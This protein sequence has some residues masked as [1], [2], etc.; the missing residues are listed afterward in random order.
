M[1]L[2]GLIYKG[3]W[4]AVT[5]QPQLVDGVGTTNYCYIIIAQSNATAYNIY[6]RNLGS[7]NKS[8]IALNYIYYNGSTWEPV[9]EGTGGGGSGT[10]TSVDASGGTGILV[11]GGPI[12]N[13]GTLH[14][15]N[16][17]PDQVVTLTPGTGIGVS[18]TYPNFSIA[19]TQSSGSTVTP[20]ALTTSGDTNITLQASGT[21]ASA[22]LQAVK[23]TV[24][25]QGTLDD[26]RISSAAIWNAKQ[27]QL[28]GAGFVKASGTTITYDNSTYL[29]SGVTS[30]NGTG[31]LYSSGT[32]AIS[33]A[34]TDSGNAG[35][36]GDSAH[37]PVITT[38]QKG[39]VTNISTTPIPLTS[40]VTSVVG[41]VGEIFASG[42]TAI[43]VGLPD[44]GIAGVY[45]GAAQLPIIT[46]DSK[47]RIT[48]IS[49]TSIYT[50][51]VTS[52][53][54]I[55]TT[56]P[57]QGGGDLSADR[58]LS[59]LQ[60]SSGA[61]GALLAA[62][63]VT[64]NSKLS[65]S[66][67]INT[68]F[69]VVG[70]GNLTVDRIFSVADA[71]ADGVTKGVSAFVA[72]DFNTTSGVTS[73]DYTNGQQSTSGTTGFLPAAD[74]NTF[75]LKVPANRVLTINGNAQD[76]SS[77]RSW[78]ISASPAGSN[79][80]V[81]Y[82]S[83][84]ST[85]GATNTLIDTDTNLVLLTSSGITTPGPSPA[86]V[87]LWGDSRSGLG[88]LHIT[89]L[90]GADY[91]LQSS[92]SQKVL[93]FLSIGSVL[94]G[95]GNFVTASNAGSTAETVKTYDGTNMLPNYAYHK[96]IAASTAN[97][98]GELFWSATGRG[99][100]MGNNVYG[101]GVKW[102][103]T[104]GFPVYSS[105]Q[106]IHVGYT[107]TASQNATTTNPSAWLNFFGLAKDSGDTTLQ[108][109]C[110]A[111]S[112]TATKVDTLI[113]PNANDVYRVTLYL[114]SNS[115]TLY[116]TLESFNKGAVTIFNTSFTGAKLMAATL[117]YTHLMVNSATSGIAVALATINL[118]EE[119]Y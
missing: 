70:G 56:S 96:N 106:R 8:W 101:G 57:L 74:W 50:S 10:V 53:R 91:L 1:A 64:F 45:G 44:K 48:N 7:G 86:G 89:P 97:S 49:T 112:G 118:I 32:T 107:N 81:Q 24:G 80:Q 94:S 25:W 68:V 69:P 47:G 84:G 104:G 65:G 37:V 59:I 6:D 33:I 39:R 111:G 15:I 62:D 66:R 3:P 17:L 28:N 61:T 18:G 100:V 119:Q 58:T 108:F 60:A 52:A 109:M 4:N 90:I 85:G 105:A 43:S 73:I 42:T 40:G 87:K 82:N 26:N 103:W 12:T 36:Y 77:N 2:S 98:S 41:A 29:T 16:T 38:D 19:N 117:I 35:T 27:S 54:A 116:C 20:A 99:A 114:P 71:A 5:N 23:L 76:L 9:E 102:V 31:G 79:L 34:L 72:S 22:L 75:N 95:T 88:Q 51:G 83:S 30:V 14:I 13:S 110:N 67:T 115:T 78:T 21:T 46:T 113:T 55:N 11:T 92:I 63:W 93:S